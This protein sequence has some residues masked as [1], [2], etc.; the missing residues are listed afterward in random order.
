MTQRELLKKEGLFLEKFS[1]DFFENKFKELP[2]E[3]E[4]AVEIII[5]KI[6]TNPTFNK[7]KTWQCIFE[8]VIKAMFPDGMGSEF[9]LNN[10]PE[11]YQEIDRLIYEFYSDPFIL[12]LD[13]AQEIYYNLLRLENPEE[14]DLNTEEACEYETWID[15]G[16]TSYG[17]EKNIFCDF[18][19]DVQ[20]LKK[21]Y[22]K[23]KNLPVFLFHEI[24]DNKILLDDTFRELNLSYMGNE[25]FLDYLYQQESD[26]WTYCDTL[27]ALIEKLNAEAGTPMQY[28]WE[29]LTNFNAICI[30]AKLYY[31][32]A[33]KKFGNKMTV[34]EIK[35]YMKYLS[36]DKALFIQICRMPNYLTRLLCLKQIFSYIEKIE[37]VNTEERFLEKLPQHL[38]ERT[39]KYVQIRQVVLR[40]SILVKWKLDRENDGFSLRKWE[41]GLEKEY[42]MSLYEELYF[43]TDIPS[44]IIK[45]KSDLDITNIPLSK[46]EREYRLIFKEALWKKESNYDQSQIF[47]E[48]VRKLGYM[49]AVEDENQMREVKFEKRLRESGFIPID[50]VML[51]C[52]WRD[53]KDSIKYIQMSNARI[54]EAEDYSDTDNQ[55]ETIKEGGVTKIRNLKPL[56]LK[57]GYG[58]NIEQRL[59]DIIQPHLLSKYK[60]ILYENTR[61]FEN[62]THKK[63]I[64]KFLLYHFYV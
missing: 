2:A 5:R 7:E 25:K 44:N 58:D 36:E 57:N 1:D 64:L 3:Y 54:I 30:L 62:D 26:K 46:K 28:I 51:N 23:D 52:L 14:I 47:S 49:E 15:I 11:E 43:S 37:Y 32:M 59:R 6:K 61:G 40:I 4:E 9:K 27:M 18:A 19:H 34:E 21:K 31:H 20:R 29:K 13:I 8:T 17:K 50:Q 35:E 22:K 63:E 24:K 55:F 38:E 60:Y 41:R 33:N 48:L 10:I 42:P 12:S 45:I 56:E 39:V 53:G 16:R